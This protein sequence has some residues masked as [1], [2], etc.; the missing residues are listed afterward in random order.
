MVYGRDE[1]LINSFV[2]RVI[3]EEDAKLRHDSTTEGYLGVDINRDANKMTLTQSGLAKRVKAFGLH[4]KY[5][6]T[7]ATPAERAA[8]P[9]DSGGE[10]AFSKFIM[11]HWLVA[12]VSPGNLVTIISSINGY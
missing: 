3:N 4:S 2:D 1:A 11:Q 9:R 6:T 5:S 8:L 7:T 10:P 12:V